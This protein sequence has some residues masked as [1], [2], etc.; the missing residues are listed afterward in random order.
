MKFLGRL[1]YFG[2]GLGMGLVLVF[3]MFGTR[4]CDWTP[5]N[6]VKSAIQECTLAA[7]AEDQCLLECNSISDEILFDLIYNGKVN[8]KDSRTKGEPKNYI[9]YNDDYKIGFDLN[10]ADSTAVLTDLYYHEDKC[11]CAP[12][13]DKLFAIHKP[14]A[15]VFS[16]MIDKGFVL[17][18][19]NKCT[20]SCFGLDETQVRSIFSD[21]E[22]D[23]TQSQLVKGKNPRYAVT[24][25]F[26]GRA[27]IFAIGVGYN[28]RLSTIKEVGVEKECGC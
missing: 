6:R 20:M 24:K 16:E 28:T 7:N 23:Y 8:F 10:L 13:G 26:K 4:G 18:D 27:Y 1:R 21:G 12:D 15:I 11:D 14:D 17:S 2:V 22:I 9:L 5:T 3:A 19:K 25:S